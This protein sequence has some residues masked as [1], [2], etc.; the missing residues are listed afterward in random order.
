VRQLSRAVHKRPVSDV[1]GRLRRIGSRRAEGGAGRKPTW[2]R[3]PSAIQASST[4]QARRANFGHAD[5]A[6]TAREGRNRYSA[7]R[8]RAVTAAR[9][10]INTVDDI[11]GRIYRPAGAAHGSTTARQVTCRSALARV[12][13]ARRIRVKGPRTVSAAQCAVRARRRTAAL[14]AGRPL[15]TRRNVCCAWR[16]AA[17]R[18]GQCAAW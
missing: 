13:S 7:P 17:S 16:W 2:R 18:R 5:V 11:T 3:G 6:Q 10:R 8:Q 15:P 12:G 4:Q 14:H 9:R 1:F